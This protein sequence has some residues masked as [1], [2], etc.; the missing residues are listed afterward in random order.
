MFKKAI[1]AITTEGRLAQLWD[2]HVWNID[3]P[4]EYDREDLQT[5]RFQGSPAAVV[6]NPATGQKAIYAITTEG[7]LAQLWDTHVWNID[8]PAEQGREDLQT[9][10]F[11]G[12]PAAVVH[13]PATGQKAIY[14]ITT[15]GRLAQLWDT[16]VWNIDFPAEY[17]RKDLQALRF[18][19]SPAAVVH[20]PA[21]GQKAIYAI[22][23]EGRLAQLWD[24]HVWNIDFP[25][26]HGRE[27]LQTL[28]FQGS[29]AVVVHNPATG[30]K[31][32]YAITT[33]GRL[34]QLWD[35]HVWNIDFPAEH[36]R[37]DLQTLRFQGSPAAVVHNPATGKKAIYAITTE[38]RLAQLWDTH[39]WNIDFPAEHGREDLQTLRFQGSPA[40]V[41]RNPATGKKA[42]Y[43]ITTEG[44][45]AQLWDTHVWNIDFPAEHGRE[46]LQ[47]LRFQGSPAVCVLY[48]LQN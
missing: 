11:Q 19:G 42:I 33:E 8:F 32:I 22:T 27:D 34:A 17:G 37:E 7:R 38:G 28:R 16:H 13:N 3:F 6:H 31:A 10:R 24:T 30:Q 46:D 41:V 25:A 20:N 43:A 36:G 29:P 14:A 15:E 48:G 39:V 4:A 2:T 1:Y 40:A 5:L 45:L 18:Q 21:T 23:T 35:T 9:L 26:E 12:N 47:T 44:R